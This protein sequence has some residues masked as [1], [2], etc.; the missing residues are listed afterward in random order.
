MTGY[1]YILVERVT[2]HFIT[3]SWVCRGCVRRCGPTF[4]ALIT[5]PPTCCHFHRGFVRSLAR[6]GATGQSEASTTTTLFNRRPLDRTGRAR[7]FTGPHPSFIHS[8]V[9]G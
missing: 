3:S 8:N 2:A 1:P 9:V 4:A 6:H 5:W 7:V